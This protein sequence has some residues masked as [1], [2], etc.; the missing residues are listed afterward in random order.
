MKSTNFALILTLALLGSYGAAS[1]HGDEDHGQEQPATSPVKPIP[2]STPAEPANGMTAVSAQRLADGSL[3][4]PKAMQ[5]Q[6]SLRTAL[7]TIREVPA[8]V[9]FNGKIIADPNASGR[10]QAGQSGRIEPGLHGLPS[11]GQKVIKGQVLAYL[12]PVASSIERGN[13]QAQLADLES[14]V[15]LAERKAK[16][17]QQLEGALPQSAIEAA[18]FESQALIKRRAAV[19]ASI[20]ASEPL[21]APAS[22]LIS[23]A[24]VVVG[25]VVEVKDILFEVVDPAR[26]AVEALAYDPA[27]VTGIASASAAV[28]GG[29]VDLQF[30]GGGRQLREQAIPLLFRIKSTNTALAVGQPLKVIAKTSRTTKGVAVAQAALVKTA[31]GELAVWIHADAERFVLRKVGQQ[32]VDATTVV[33]TSGVAQGERVVTQGAGLLSQVR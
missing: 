12:R 21:L 32:P 7:A 10:V 24:N 9:E 25:Q 16:R 6:L 29:I 20:N 28:S 22:G 17:Y 14:Q 19:G 15:T 1:A 26:L 31:T 5:Y 4:V 23:A 27:L 11:L 2:G 18:R 8:T 30:V 13:Q 33:L 3:F